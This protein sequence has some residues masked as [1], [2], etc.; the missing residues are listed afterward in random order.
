MLIN[1]EVVEIREN[2][3]KFNTTEVLMKEEQY[4]WLSEFNQKPEVLG[5]NHF[6]K[7]LK[8]YDT[9]LRD[10]EQTIGVSFDKEGEVGDRQD[11]GRDGG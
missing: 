9:T 1:P 6:P 3:I 8:I 5:E 11:A 2:A 4:W 7:E 10:G